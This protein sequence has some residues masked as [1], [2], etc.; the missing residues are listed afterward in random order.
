[1]ICC[2]HMRNPAQDLSPRTANS[3]ANTNAPPQAFRPPLGGEGFEST[4]PPE[5]L[6]ELL[7]RK[8]RTRQ[9]SAKTKW[10]CPPCLRSALTFGAAVL[11]PASMLAAIAAAMW[12]FGWTPKAKHYTD[13]ALERTFHPMAQTPSP[14]L[15]STPVVASTPSPTVVQ[16]PQIYTEWVRRGSQAGFILCYGDCTPARSDFFQPDP[17][18]H[19]LPA[20]PRAE[21]VTMPVRRA[22]LVRN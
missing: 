11:T 22:T 3:R 9:Q 12:A 6:D 8:P 19:A 2:P 18:P 4:L 13:P 10:S 1:V 14:V 21:L 20:A 5:A 7:R 15:A 16:S 17:A